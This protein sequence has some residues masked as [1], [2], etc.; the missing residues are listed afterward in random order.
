MAPF[1]GK[2]GVCSIYVGNLVGPTINTNLASIMRIDPVKVEFFMPEPIVIRLVQKFGSIKAAQSA[3]VAK[4]VLA[5]GSPYT[6]EG[7][8]YFANNEVNTGTGTLMMRARFPNPTGILL[9]G[10]YAKVILHTKEPI[11]AILVPQLTILRD[12]TGE[13]VMTVDKNHKVERRQVKT[14]QSHGRAMQ[15]MEG[16]SEGDMVVSQGLL[17]IRPGVTVSVTVDS[18]WSAD[19]DQPKTK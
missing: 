6:Q 12:Q 7:S 4:L 16:I 18:G 2:L 9:P 10:Q 11:S 8:I 17:K 19:I 13:Y 1:D 15:V 14:G 5:N 3:V